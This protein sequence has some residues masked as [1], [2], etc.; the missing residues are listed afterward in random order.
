MS[1]YIIHIFSVIAFIIVIVSLYQNLTE[2]QNTQ[3]YWKEKTAVVVAAKNIEP[4]T[5]LEESMLSVAQWERRYLKDKDTTDWPRN[6]VGRVVLY[7]I[8]KGN[9]LTY[10]NTSEKTESLGL[11]YIIPKGKRAVSLQVSPQNMN[12]ALLKPGDNVDIFIYDDILWKSKPL[13]VQNVEILAVLQDMKRELTD[14]K[15]VVKYDPNNDKKDRGDKTPWAITV[16]LSFYEA[17]KVLISAKENNT[18]LMVRDRNDK[19][20]INT[21]KESQYLIKEKLEESMIVIKGSESKIIYA[22]AIGE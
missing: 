22:P 13:V 5:V 18:Y 19:E 17:Q 1:K 21:E 15:G 8:N 7:K 6:M 11:S 4:G 3:K 14:R 16:A 20:Y 9:A 2:E 10:K 12:S